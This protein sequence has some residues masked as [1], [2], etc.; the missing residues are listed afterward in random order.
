M[1]SQVLNAFLTVAP[2]SNP[3]RNTSSVLSNLTTPLPHI[4]LISARLAIE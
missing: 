1:L 3:L 2:D 4:S